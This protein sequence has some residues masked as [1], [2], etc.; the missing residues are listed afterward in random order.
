MHISLEKAR[1]ISLGV[2]G[3]MGDMESAGRKL[4]AKN[5]KARMDRNPDLS[6]QTAL[7]GKSGVA[8]SYISR[9]L[10]SKSGATIDQIW[11]IAKAFGCQPFELLVDSEEIRRVAI[12]RVL[13]GPGPDARIEQLGTPIKLPRER[14]HD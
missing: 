12:E 8:Q 6:S 4:L 11:K 2:A 10:R 14:G 3:T 9:I 13:A 5:I 7:A 1:P